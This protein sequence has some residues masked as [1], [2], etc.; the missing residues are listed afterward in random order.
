M[1]ILCNESFPNSRLRRNRKNPAIRNLIAQT[2]ISPCNL[3]LPIF[4]IE[5]QN[6]IIEVNNSTQINRYS[7]D[8]ALEI[9]KKAYAKNISAIML[10]PC[11]DHNLKN[12]EATEAFNSNNLINRAIKAFKKTL[13]DLQVITDVA[14]DPYTSHGHDGIIDSD[15]LVKND[16]TIAILIKQALAQAQCGCDAVAPSDMMDGRV[17]QIRQALDQNGFNHVNIISYSAKYASALYTPFREIVGSSHNLKKADKKNYQMDYRNSNEALREVALDLNEG[18]DMIII[19]PATFYLDI[20]AHVKQNFAVPIIG[21]Q[22]SGEYAMLKSF[23]NLSYQEFL[24]LYYESLIAIKRAG[25]D[26]IIT[27][28]ALEIA[29]YLAT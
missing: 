5:G 10:F 12:P 11:I 28:G 18:A 9:A 25:A 19:K 2:H 6:L 23:K 21:Y 13:P 20:I 15:G 8:Q 3:I 7:I 4:L 1:T 16:D 26:A 22:V 24:E 29:D 14:L 27:Y 17:G